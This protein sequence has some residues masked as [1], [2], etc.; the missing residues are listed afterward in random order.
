MMLHRVVA[1]AVEV[2]R[3]PVAAVS[4]VLTRPRLESVVYW[5]RKEC[6]MWSSLI[7]KVDGAA[8][9]EASTL[10]QVLVFCHPYFVLFYYQSPT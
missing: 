8:A 5:L 4:V 6:M 7:E 3:R 9:A 2:L 1:A 10:Y